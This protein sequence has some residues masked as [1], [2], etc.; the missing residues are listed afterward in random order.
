M[1]EPIAGNTEWLKEL[2]DLRGIRIDQED[3]T[4]IRVSSRSSDRESV[5]PAGDRVPEGV[6]RLRIRGGDHLLDDQH[7]RVELGHDHG[8]GT[9][10]VPRRTEGG[11]AGAVHRCAEPRSLVH[12]GRREDASPLPLRIDPLVDVNRAT[13][14]P[15]VI[16]PGCAHEEPRAAQPDGGA[17][18]IAG[19]RVRRGQGLALDPNSTDTLEQRDGSRATVAGIRGTGGE[20]DSPEVDARSPTGSGNRRGS[21]ERAHLVPSGAAEREDDNRALLA[22]ARERTPG[23]DP[24]GPT[25]DRRS[26][27]LPRL[28]GGRD[29]IR[30]WGRGT[31]GVQS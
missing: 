20:P 28:G 18:L 2:G 11:S 9:G 4:G 31:L 30:Q 5:T 1:A 14:R 8:S 3:R 21:G 13:I 25:R 15:C 10:S 29:E 27:S 19:L 22:R 16:I 26:E 23:C 12:G 17:E 24:R 6:A 7:S